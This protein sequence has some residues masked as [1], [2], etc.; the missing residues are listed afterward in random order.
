MVTCQPIW[1]SLLIYFLVTTYSFFTIHNTIVITVTLRA[2]FTCQSTVVSSFYIHQSHAQKKK[3]EK[4]QL[5]LSFST[6]VHLFCVTMQALCLFSVLIL[7]L[8][9]ILN[10]FF[11]VSL[12]V[13]TSHTLV[14]YNIFKTFSFYDLTSMWGGY[15]KSI[16]SVSESYGCIS[17]ML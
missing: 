16:L 12:N 15:P 3:K 7:K 11:L 17:D 4:K 14:V 5:V 6:S 9:L 8:Q 13:L 1:V 2:S 10:Y